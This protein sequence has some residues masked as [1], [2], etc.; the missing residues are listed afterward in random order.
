VH[1]VTMEKPVGF[2]YDP[3]TQRPMFDGRQVLGLTDV[4]KLSGIMDGQMWGTEHDLWMGQCRHAAVEL[5]VKG[6]LDLDTVHKDILPSI[7]AFLEFQSDT[8]FK[9]THSELK[10]WSPVYRVATRIDL[11]GE[12]PDGSEAII[13]LKSG[14]CAKPTAIQTAGQDSLLN[15]QKTRKRFGL[16]IPKT[17]K[18]KVVPYTNRD[19]Y[20]IWIAAMNIAHWKI[21]ELGTKF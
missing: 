17:G 8:G 19:D 21:K 12:F 1:G 20:S 10:V 3:I 16:S 18:P 5:W 7:E 13:E 9:P 15:L 4:L 11:M 14:A 2:D 6:T